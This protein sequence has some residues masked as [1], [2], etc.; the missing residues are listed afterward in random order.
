M[1]FSVL[2]SNIGNSSPRVGA[3]QAT[4][5]L[6]ARPEQREAYH[7]FV[8]SRARESAEVQAVLKAEFLE[9][10]AARRAA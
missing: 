2:P 8:E 10:D 6:T 5:P 3:F 7:R 4:L 1:T 9:R